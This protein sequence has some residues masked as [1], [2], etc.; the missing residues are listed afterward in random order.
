MI[1][2]ANEK[3]LQKN[4]TSIAPIPAEEWLRLSSCLRKVTL[5]SGEYFV[6]AGDKAHHIGFVVRGLLKKFYRTDEGQEFIK[7]FSVE[8]SLVTSYSSLLQST[9]S[10]LNIQATENTELLVIPY[11]DFIAMYQFH[12]CWQELGRKIAENL[13][14]EREQREWELLIFP[15]KA[16]YEMFKERYPNLLGRV[17]QYEIA[18]YLGISPISLS[19]LIG[20]RQSPQKRIRS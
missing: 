3:I 18:S 9:P 11:A 7:D 13:F 16:R 20:K 8:A 15:A 6:K 1:D 2:V 19:R 10:R 14:I 4:L 12:V 17:P 5:A